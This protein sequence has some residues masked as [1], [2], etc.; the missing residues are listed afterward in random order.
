MADTV[1]TIVSEVLQELGVLGPGQPLPTTLSDIVLRRYNRLLDAWNAEPDTTVYA[2][3]FTTYT[4]TASLSPHT[5][6]PT[7]A[8]WTVTQRPV[9]IKGAS[10][11]LGTNPNVKIP[12][13]IR[14]A[15]WWNARSIPSLST[16]YPTDLY[17]DLLWPN[18][19][20]YFWPVPAA[21]YDVELWTRIVLAQVT[22]DSSFSLPPGYWRAHVLS[23]AEEAAEPLGVDLS[24]RLVDQAGKARAVIYGANRQT[25]RIA[26]RDAGMPHGGRTKTYNYYSREG[27]S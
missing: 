2:D 21:A 17:P 18:A 5:L 25:P 7:G 10:L 13:N 6:G 8:T 23:L 9:E 12:L 1:R 15:A 14:D 24:P 11:W 27:V 22:L 4:L 3:T 16:N 26:S 20:L 19:S